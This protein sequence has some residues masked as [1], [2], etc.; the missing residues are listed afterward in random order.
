VYREKDKPI[1]QE[2]IDGVP[3]DPESLDEAVAR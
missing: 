2:H 1:R 3:D